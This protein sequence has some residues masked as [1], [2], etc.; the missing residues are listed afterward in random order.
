MFSTFFT[1]TI[2]RLSAIISTIYMAVNSFKSA[3]IY[4]NTF[5]LVCFVILIKTVKIAPILFP[6][7]IFNGGSFAT[8][9]EQD[10]SLNFKI[11][12]NRFLSR[13]ILGEMPL[14]KL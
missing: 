13:I 10:F 9:K 8:C 11:L 3:S 12:L 6:A 14:L 7:S 2:Y 4:K 1:E 5:L